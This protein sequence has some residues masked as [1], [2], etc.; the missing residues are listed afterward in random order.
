MQPV[1]AGT[2][3]LA[4]DGAAFPFLFIAIYLIIEKSDRVAVG[5]CSRFLR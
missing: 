3:V 1:L 5:A 2:N 4:L